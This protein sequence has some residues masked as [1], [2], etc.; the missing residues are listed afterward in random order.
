MNRRKHL[1]DT[2]ASV[3]RRFILCGYKFYVTVGFYDNQQPGEIFVVVAKQG[4]TLA[5]LIDAWAVAVSLLLQHGISWADISRK[6]IGM[7]FE[8]MQEPDYSSPIDALIKHVSQIISD[9]GGAADYDYD[10]KP[11]EQSPQPPA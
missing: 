7:R 5:G 11:P 9:F 3:T 6:Y 10:G 8:P 2:R 1:P 4:T